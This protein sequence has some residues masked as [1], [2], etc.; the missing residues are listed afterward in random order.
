MLWMWIIQL[1]WFNLLKN[2]TEKKN[3]EKYKLFMSIIL[4]PAFFQENLNLT[5]FNQVRAMSSYGA[6]GAGDKPRHAANDHTTE[7]FIFAEIE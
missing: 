3:M 1:H 7:K 2:V 6:V 4:N 5:K